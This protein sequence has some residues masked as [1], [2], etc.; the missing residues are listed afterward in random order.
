MASSG[1]CTSSTE[2]SIESVKR[3][4]A[5]SGALASEEGDND[6]VSFFKN[7]SW[8]LIRGNCYKRKDGG[9]SY[10]CY[11][12]QS[13]E[14]IFHRTNGRRPTCGQANVRRKLLA[15]TLKTDGSIYG[16]KVNSALLS[17]CYSELLIIESINT[18]VKKTN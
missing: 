4:A 13:E 10:P 5:E 15:E 2:I 17:E 6:I 18:P 3:Y 16:G 12:A 14:G 11:D 7:S 9:N 8:D 1:T